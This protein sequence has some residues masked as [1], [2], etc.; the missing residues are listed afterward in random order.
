MSETVPATPENATTPVQPDSPRV[1]RNH[2]KQARRA[3]SDRPKKPPEVDISPAAGDW[4]S[5]RAL[6]AQIEEELEAA[7]GGMSEQE[8]FA[9]QPKPAGMPKQAPGFKTG[10]VVAIH[11][12]DVFVEF[13]GNKSQGMLPITQFPEGPPAIGTHVEVTIERY[14]PSNGILIVTREGAVAAAHWSTLEIGQIVEARVIEVNKGGLSVEVNG[15]RGFLPISQIDLYRVENAEQFVNQRLRCMVAEADQ[16]EKNLVVSRRALLEREREE[17]S[18]NLWEEIAEG[19]VRKGFVRQVKPFG[20]FVDLGGVNG[21]V[22]VSEMSWTRVKDATEVMSPGQTVE[23]VVTRVDREARKVSLSLRQLM[24]SPWD[25]VQYNFPEK[26]VATGKVTRLA[27]FGAFVELEGG[28]EG[29]VHISELAIQ[30]VRRP[31]DVVQV[32]DMVQVRIMRIDREAQKLSLSMKAVKEAEKVEAAAEEEAAPE[33]PTKPRVKRTDLKGGI[34][35]GGPLFPD[36][37]KK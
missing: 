28:L 1:L 29:L 23:V 33:E 10:I 22:P 9:E 37:G 25:T 35:S 15:I 16:Q 27:E 6:D 4:P 18:K 3:R 30:R 11:G 31:G 32:G 36:L 21:L 12:G 17:A 14:D 24:A 5:L 34:G 8:M 2:E 7:M 20:A 13:P 19:Q 26:S